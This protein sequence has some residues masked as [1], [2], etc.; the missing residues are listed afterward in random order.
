MGLDRS[1]CTMNPFLQTPARK[2]FP[3]FKR[4]SLRT[5]SDAVVTMLRTVSVII[6]TYNYGRFIS[7]AIRSVLN[8]TYQAVELIVVD[9]G[10]ND[11]TREVVSEFGNSVKYIRQHNAGVCA[12]R[13]AGVRES[14]GELIAFLDADDLWEPTHL[15]K[16]VERFADEA[17]GLVHSGMREFDSQ[18][19]ETLRLYV[20]GAEE[21]AARNLLLWEAPHVNVS[22][23]A[24]MVLRTAFDE[25]GGFDT[26]IKVG[27]DWDF[28]YRIA[29]HYKVAFVPEPLVN[30]RNHAAAAHRDVGEMERGM[31]LFYEKAF[32]D[33]GEILK[34]RRRALG[35]FHRVL[36]GSYFQTGQYSRFL[37][38]AL[39]CLWYR[40]AT[41]K[42]F[43]EFPLRRLRSESRH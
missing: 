35:N 14:K 22:G 6:P 5:P 10:S 33:G 28:C 3:V 25:V 26:R 7:H 19:G 29:K 13:M 11:N 43:I 8:Q 17:V 34:L 37:I 36:S 4:K 20:D 42:Y 15:E 1:T 40:P 2:P 16:Q 21:D 18:S 32:A 41:I 31:A 38:N 24:V 23:S 9:D 39:K 30:Y 27:E 12:A